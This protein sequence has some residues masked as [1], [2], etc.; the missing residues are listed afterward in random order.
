VDPG[1]VPDQ[2]SFGI[3]D[4]NTLPIPTQGTANEL[5]SV[6]IDS[7]VPN[8]DTFGS[9]PGSGFNIGAPGVTVVPEPASM[10]VAF[11][12][13]CGIAALIR[14]RSARDRAIATTLPIA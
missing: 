9:T 7:A 1:G 10:G 12:S 2:F 8:I 6:N 3:V 5:L 14:T 4:K 11:A 13:L